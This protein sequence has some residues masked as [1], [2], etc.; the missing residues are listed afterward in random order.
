VTVNGTGVQPLD[1]D[2]ELIYKASGDQHF[3][4]LGHGVRACSVAGVEHHHREIQSHDFVP[5]SRLRLVPDPK[6]PHDQNAIEVRSSDGKLIAGFVP[7]GIAA[8]L[9]PLFKRD[10]PWEAMSVWEWR[11]QARGRVGIRMLLAPHLEVAAATAQPPLPQ[12]NLNG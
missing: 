11:T 3:D 7:R 12:R 4:Y 6:N 1:Q 10:G 8:D 9:A 5:G 2:G